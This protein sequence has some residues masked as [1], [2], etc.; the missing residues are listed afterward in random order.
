[1]PTS[2][3]WGTDVADLTA[4]QQHAIGRALRAAYFAARRRDDEEEARNLYA[5][6]GSLGMR[7]Y[8]PEGAALADLREDGP[9]DVEARGERAGRTP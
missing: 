8:L 4:E 3:G 9:A 5:A 6:A 2:S 1:M 7:N